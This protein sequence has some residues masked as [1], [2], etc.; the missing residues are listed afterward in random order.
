MNTYDVKQDIARFLQIL[1]LSLEEFAD[2]SG[3]SRQTINNILTDSVKP[4]DE[5]LEKIY[6]YA[7][8]CEVNLNKSKELLLKDNEGDSKLLFHGARGEIIG[9]VDTKHSM[10]P[11]DFGNGFYAGESLQQSAS[12]V[13]R[14]DSSSVYCFYLKNISSMN[15]L[16]FNTDVD[17]LY[18][19]LYY[20]G[21]FNRFVVP[22]SIKELIDK[23]EKCDLIIAP[24]A[25]NEMFKI[26]DYF[27]K[28]EIT[29]EACL[30]AISATNLGIQYVCKS[31]LACQNLV[32]K[33][34]LYLC[35][36]EK[37]DFLNVKDKL[38]SEG[39]EKSRLA[40]I[41]Y[42]RKGK[43]FDEIFQRKR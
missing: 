16:R 34:R 24:I 23:V 42:R 5:I 26:I 41:D 30:H 27:S 35:K 29:D 39:V 38:T 37:D 10:P 4:S 2:C 33:D 12:W 15:I 21:A 18:I 28:N 40:L 11:N 9:P 13:S 22:N 31:D 25:D 3:V 19:V 14:Y 43:Y 8:F 17:W 6:S 7:Y 36:K 20:R 32:F 1:D